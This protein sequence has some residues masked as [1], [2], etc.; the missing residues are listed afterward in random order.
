MRF[1]KRIVALLLLTS[2][3]LFLLTSCGGKSN[4]VVIEVEG[5]GKIVIQLKP[6]VAPITV[7]NFKNLVNSGF[8]NGLTFHRIADLTYQ[9]GYIVQGGCPEGNGT[10]STTPIKG[11]FSAN[12]VTNDL[13]HVRGV[14]SMARSNAYDSG[15]CQFFICAGDCTFLDGNYA[16]FAVVIKGLD[17][18]D[19]IVEDYKANPNIKIVMTRVY[20]K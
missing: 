3:A 4:K 2:M 17:V 9:G 20:V 5:Y 18:V 15:S 14:V 7:E 13:S 11:E 10:G 12:G 6:D 8:Y 19:K 1:F 16:A